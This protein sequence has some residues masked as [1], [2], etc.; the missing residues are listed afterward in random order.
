MASES[1]QIP[2]PN[3]SKASADTNPTPPEKRTH[4]RDPLH[5][6]TL[7]MIVKHLVA[8]HG[9]KEMGRR[10]P[11]RCFLFNPDVKSSLTFLRKTPWARAKVEDW[12]LMDRADDAFKK[13]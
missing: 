3:N 10:I 13:E 4:P 7:E 12:F 1:E 8:R 11:I 5:G 6:V 9:W 2:N